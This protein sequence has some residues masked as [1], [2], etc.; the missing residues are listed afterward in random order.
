MRPHPLPL[1]QMLLPLVVVQQPRRGAFSPVSAHQTGNGCGHSVVTPYSGT[2]TS[3]NY[4]GTYPNFT[5][6]QWS[7]QGATGRQLTF[8]FGDM[9]IEASEQCKSGFL[10]LSSSSL[11][12]SSFGPY[13]GNSNPPQAALVM[14]ST[15]VTILFNSTTHRSGRGFL[16]SYTSGNQPG[17][18][19]CLKKGIHYDKELIRAY[20]PAGCK[21]VTGDIWGNVDQGY[22]DTSVLCKAAVHAGMIL[23]EQGGE[24]TVSQGKGISLYESAYANGLHSKRGSLSEKRLL[25]HKACAGTLDIASFN[26]SSC[27]HEQ[28]AVGQNK[29][30]AAEQAAL[31]AD[32]GSWAADQNSAD[33]WLE[34]DLGGRRN[35]TGIITKGSPQH[36]YYVKS[37]QILS[38]RDGKNWKVYKSSGAT[39]E[40]IFVGNS[41]SH[42]T[43]YN[44]FIPPILA[45]YL[46]VAPKDWNQRIALKVAL[47]GCQPARLKALRPYSDSGIHSGPLEVPGLTSSPA[48]FTT[49]P[50]IAI[51]SAKTGPPLLVM[52]L[53]GGFVLFSSALLLLVFLCHKKSRKTAVDQDCGLIKGYPALEASQVCSRENL[54]L[55]TAEITLFP[56]PE[57]TGIHSGA[58]SPEYA[59]PDV[60]QVSPASQTAPSTFKPVPEE[61]YTL[62][63]VVNHYDVP[64]KYHE[65]AEPLPPEPEYAT[66]FTDQPSAEPEG[67]TYQK[68]PCVIK[69]ISSSLSQAS[70]LT[71]PGCSEQYDFPAQRPAETP[72]S[73]ASETGPGYRE[74]PGNQPLSPIDGFP[75]AQ[76]A[77]S[78]EGRSFQL[79]HSP[80]AHVYH[81]PL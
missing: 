58:Q 37:Y 16:L 53:I 11:D 50:G 64:G 65:Y 34:A 26:A 5:S 77:T 66:P 43:V 81:E 25:F 54:H 7:I 75:A 44:A 78:P 24:I 60:V 71:S 56:G 23:D 62:P 30:W 32:G 14:N 48:T 72:D 55:S 2:L 38:S 13:C 69:V 47:L 63:L 4:P 45:R 40:K 18:I 59:E 1:F 67:Y 41:N 68:S 17:L 36:N 39:E 27:W 21:D 19:S 31:G 49:V 33:E 10:L 3:K 29:V 46:R 20:C 42:Q 73:K 9:D 28:D 79:R 12:G 15:S 35:I 74:P 61:G 52:L 8:A 70:S 6:C 76:P 51:N 22:R 80:L 57:T